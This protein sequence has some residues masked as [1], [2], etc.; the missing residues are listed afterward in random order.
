MTNS[1]DDISNEARAYFIIGSNTT[2]NHPVLG[3]RLR[4][5]VKTRGA[6]L[7]LC[8]PRAIPI[9]K[10]ATLHIRQRPGNGHRPAQRDHARSHPGRSLRQA[11]RG[12]TNGRVR[13]AQGQGGRVPS[14]AGPPHSAAS[15]PKRSSA[16]PRLLAEHRPG[17]ALY[18]MGITQH[19]TGHSNVL[20]VA[21]LQMLLGNMGVPGGGVNPLRGQNNVQGACDMG[22]LPNVFPGYQSVTSEEVRAKFEKAWGLLPGSAAA[23]AGPDRGGDD[24]RRPGGERAN[25]LHRGRKPHGHR[26]RPEPRRRSL[27]RTGLSRRPGHLSHRNGKSWPTS[28]SREPPSRR[29]R[30]PSP[31][32]SGGSRR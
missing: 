24:E 6:V 22:G 27:G 7:V 30:G 8:D 18:A 9:S 25:P 21:N 16:P 2:E 20:S 14:R 26:S 1:L 3:M 11:V 10:F 32:R 23:E 5:A 15:S 13:G 17:A 19:T 28:S 29:N 12:G 31:I 4:Q